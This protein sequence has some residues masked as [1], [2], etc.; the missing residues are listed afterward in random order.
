MR[1]NNSVTRYGN[2]SSFLP[3][4]VL[5]RR[6]QNAIAVPRRAT[7]KTMRC[8]KTTWLYVSARKLGQL[9][10]PP[11]RRIAMVLMW[12]SGGFRDSR[13][14]LQRA[15]DDQVDGARGNGSPVV[16]SRGITLRSV[17]CDC[18]LSALGPSA[19]LQP[20]LVHRIKTRT[21]LM[22]S[23]ERLF[24]AVRG[25]WCLTGYGYDGRCVTV[26]A[27]QIRAC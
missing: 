13:Q 3:A 1:K 26:V 17:M 18:A 20:D 16:L 19:C 9:S 4:V 14:R 10:P 2:P 12:G 25:G 11:T 22:P 27:I 24:E 8:A 15:D 6:A 23:T 5:V 21:R 7:R